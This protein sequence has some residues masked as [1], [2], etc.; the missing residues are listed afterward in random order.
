[1]LEPEEFVRIPGL[2]RLW[3]LQ[4]VINRTDDYQMHYV[5]L[6]GD[7]TPL[8]AVYRRAQGQAGRPARWVAQ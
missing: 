3:D 1:M 6:T 5:E 4:S 2:Y 7:G 8:F